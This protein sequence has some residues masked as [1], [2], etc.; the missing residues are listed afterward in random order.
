MKSLK[1]VKNNMIAFF[2][3][4]LEVPVTALKALREQEYLYKHAS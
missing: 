1:L 2:L 4:L 3:E